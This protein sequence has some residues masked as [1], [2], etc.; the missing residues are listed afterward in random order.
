M[1]ESFVIS[2]LHVG[3]SD[4]IGYF[5]ETKNTTSSETN[6]LVA[7]RRHQKLKTLVKFITGTH[8]FWFLSRM[9]SFNRIF[10]ELCTLP[11]QKTAQFSNPVE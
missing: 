1:I 2:I 11:R 8:Q 10:T 9:N 7:I 3:R 5:E 6:L 4:E